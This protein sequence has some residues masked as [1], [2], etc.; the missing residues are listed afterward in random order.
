MYQRVVFCLA[1]LIGLTADAQTINLRGVVSNWWQIPIAN[2]SITLVRQAIQTT[3]AAT[4]GAYSITR[5]TAVQLPALPRQ[6]ER[7]VLNKGVLELSL[8]H[9]SPVKVEVYDI[10]GNLLKRESVPNATSGAC[11]INLADNTRAVSLLVVKL[12]IGKR[13]M[14][15]RYMPLNTAMYLLDMTSEFSPLVSV[16]NSAVGALAAAVDS[17]RTTANGYTQ[18]TIPISTY[19]STVNIIL[20]SVPGPSVGCGKTLGS[21]NKSGTY[22]ITSS[23]T[24]RTYI[25]DIPTNYDKNKPYRLIFGMHCMGGSA[26]K[27]S[28]TDGTNDQTAYYYHLKPLATSDSIPCIYV[29]PQGNSDGTWQGAPDHIFFSDMLKLFKD[30]LCIDTTRV[31]SVGFSFG[32]MF[33]YSLSLEFQNVL[34]AVVCYAPANYNMYQPTNKHLPLAYMQTTGTSDG[35]CPWINSDPNQQGGKY[36]LLDHITDNG[37][38]V[39]SSFKLATSGTHVT[40]DYPGCKV[41]YPVKFCS[42]QGG[43]QC[44]A[45]DAGSSTNWIPVE[46]WKFLKQF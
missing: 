10:K 39:P 8:P 32:A 16:S 31:F 20:D 19:D 37:C 27:V 30:T 5:S 18:K 38:T 4:T 12:S 3:S 26:I 35:T 34:R 44:N 2:A 21:I 36:C 41:G 17:L 9:S 13:E 43:H 7:L 1:V 6:T 22:T 23:G 33:S 15:F 25:I 42:F 29:A 28:G 40:T 45:T 11:R 46:S 14:S 24:N